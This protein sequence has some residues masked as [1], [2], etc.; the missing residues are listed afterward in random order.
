[1]NLSMDKQ[2]ERKPLRNW[3]IRTGVTMLVTGSFY[4]AFGL[5][6]FVPLE[7]ESIAWNNIRI[8]SGVAIVGCLLA[9]VG[10]GDE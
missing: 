1:M 6:G 9:A 2:L 8:V 7:L 3:L 10:Y 4:L 5:L